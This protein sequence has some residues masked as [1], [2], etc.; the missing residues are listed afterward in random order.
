MPPPSPSAD[1]NGIAD[2]VIGWSAFVLAGFTL[3]IS[4]L[5]VLF[6]VAGF[7]GIREAR[8]L[9]QLG[10]RARDELDRQKLVAQEIVDQANRAVDVAATLSTEANTLIQRVQDAVAVTEAQSE[11][12]RQLND[13]L[14]GRLADLDQRLSTQVEVSYLFN[15][16]EAAYRDG[17][18]EKAVEYLR[19]AVELDPRNPRVRYRLGRS[20]TNLGDDAEAAQELRT[21]LDLGLPADA[22][23]RALALVYRYTQPEV[24][25]AHA[26]QAIE[27][28]AD[29]AHNWN[30]LGLIRRDGGDFAGSREAHQRANQLDNELITTPFYLALLAAQARAFPHARDRSAEAMT[31]LEAGERRARIKPM[32]AALIRWADQVLRAAYPE[33]EG[34]VRQLE[35]NCRSSRRAREI[36]DHMEFLL[37]SLG[38]EEYR[39]RYVEPIE[40]RWLRNHFK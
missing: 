34:Y 37:R 9:R 24:A 32:W 29:N 19:R 20:L 36:C 22:G 14:Q 2:L 27:A 11:Q 26:A 18:Y 3:L 21:A 7:V 40:Q 16:G 6:L 25:L 4:V 33:A 10:E 39:E 8:S 38:R 23:E 30:C 5:T 13:D 28:G 1:P 15:Q 31:R 12:V 17:Q 35:E